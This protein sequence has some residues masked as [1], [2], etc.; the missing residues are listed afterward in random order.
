MGGWDGQAEREAC[1]GVG[2][3]GKGETLMNQQRDGRH[4]GPIG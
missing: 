2:G 4:G 1:L 3:D